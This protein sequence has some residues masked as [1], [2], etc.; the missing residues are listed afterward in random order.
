MSY[1]IYNDQ[2][3]VISIS[4]SSNICHFFVLETFRILTSSYFEIYN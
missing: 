2:I 3:K 4:I 1:I